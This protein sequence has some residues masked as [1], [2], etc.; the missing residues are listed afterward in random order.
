MKELFTHDTNFTP[1]IHFDYEKGRLDIRGKSLPDDANDFYDPFLQW[2]DDYSKKPQPKT[3][4]NIQFAYFN[5]SSSKNILEIFKKLAVIKN[6]GFD[7]E[8]NW[9]YDIEEDDMREAGDDYQ[10]IVK[11]PFNLI[12]YT[13]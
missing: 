9:Y 7:V 4:V 8:I 1:K 10:T 11:I 2:I 13:R 5:T 3:L 12:S 6:A